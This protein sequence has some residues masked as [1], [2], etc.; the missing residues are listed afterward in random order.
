MRL[1]PSLLS[2]VL[3]ACGSSAVD[4]PKP[5]SSPA[6]PSASGPVTN[7][8]AVKAEPIKAEPIKPELPVTAK[9]AAPIPPKPSAEPKPAASERV[10]FGRTSRT[11]WH[12]GNLKSSKQLSWSSKTGEYVAKVR[13]SGWPS[14]VTLKM[15]IDNHGEGGYME[16]IYT[17]LRGKKIIGRFS[18]ADYDL[19]T[20]A[21]FRAM[22]PLFVTSDGLAV[23]STVAELRDKHSDVRCRAYD[24]GTYQYGPI[25]CE[26]ASAP[27]TRFLLDPSGFSQRTSRD[28]APV[29]IAAIPNRKVVQ[30]VVEDLI[31][32]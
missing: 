7:V 1:F 18:A 14:D 16:E 31:T 12:I 17:L 11:K 6:T 32:R 19:G 24:P 23:G 29:Q 28:G 21:T 9:P 27:S 26:T 22:D 5:S 20:Q 15:D 30:I 13:N 8:E 10:V 2:V 25:E 3:F 4:Q